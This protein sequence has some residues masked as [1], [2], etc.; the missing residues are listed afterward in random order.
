MA[1][2]ASPK[3]CASWDRMF[4]PDKNCPA[5]SSTVRNASTI[6]SPSAAATPSNHKDFDGSNLRVVLVGILGILM[7]LIILGGIGRYII[8]QAARKARAAR[9]E[10]PASRRRLRDLEMGRLKKGLSR[11]RSIAKPNPEVRVQSRRTQEAPLQPPRIRPATTT[12]L[13]SPPRY[14]LPNYHN[15]PLGTPIAAEFMSARDPEFEEAA[16]VETPPPAYQRRNGDRYHWEEDGTPA[17]GYPYSSLRRAM[18][19]GHGGHDVWR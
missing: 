12:R 1:E 13:G 7:F 6:P 3:W 14:D 10:Q 8:H 11:V 18:I 5:P 4:H 2:S 17:P 15:T 19:E 9:G 16:S